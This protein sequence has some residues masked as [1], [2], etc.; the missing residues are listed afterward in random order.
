MLSRRAANPMHYLLILLISLA[1]MSIVPILSENFVNASETENEV[2]ITYNDVESESTDSE[3]ISDETVSDDESEN[4]FEEDSEEISDENDEIISEVDSSEAEYEEDVDEEES[5]DEDES[6]SELSEQFPESYVPYLESVQEEHPSWQFVPAET[7][8]SWEAAVDSQDEGSNALL[9]PEA[10]KKQRENSDKTYDGDWYLASRDTI[11]YYM[12]P[13]NFL[14][15]EDIFQFLNQS[16]DESSQNVDTVSSVIEGSF[17][18]D[19]DPKGDYDS[20]EACIEAAGREAGV[21]PNILASMIIMEQ[22]WD[23]SSLSSGNKKGYKGYYNFFNIGA[24]TTDDMSA[25]ERGLWYAKGE[26]E[27]NTSYERPWDS[28]YKAILGGAQFYYE[29]YV[30]SGQNTYYTK[31]YNVMNG[32]GEL[33]EHQYMTNVA[34]ALGEGQ[35]V[36]KAYE[37]TDLPVVFEIPVYE[38]MPEETCKLP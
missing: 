13:R 7:G 28:P 32:E 27:G 29:N 36:R 30:S 3:E 25:S 15:D 12:D 2:D 24:W 26:G 18:E 23:G 37:G 31:K 33:G 8:I 10:P 6:D 9:W 35:L 1:L 17:M 21:N 4:N 19:E 38:N 5:E 14:N 20:Y 34:G 16:Y 22:G 11:E